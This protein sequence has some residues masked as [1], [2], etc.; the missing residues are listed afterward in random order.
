[1]FKWLILG[2][3]GYLDPTVEVEDIEEGEDEVVEDNLG[4]E[5]VE[6]SEKATQVKV[7]KQ[8]KPP[9][10]SKEPK[11]ASAKKRGRKPKNHQLIPNVMSPKPVNPSELMKIDALISADLSVVRGNGPVESQFKSEE[12]K[13]TISSLIQQ[14]SRMALNQES[15][16]TASSP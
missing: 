11:E 14:E 2:E 6:F 15:I 1:M 7:K 8:I 10:E 12:S 9:K 16:T 5:T 13:V 3:T 4:E